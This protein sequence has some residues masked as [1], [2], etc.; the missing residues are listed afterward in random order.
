MEA[1]KITLIDAQADVE[2]KLKGK[3]AHILGRFRGEV[4]LSGRLLLGEGSRV[5][6]K[7][8]ADLA[9]VAG[10][11]KGEIVA[12]VV[13]LAERAR[14]QGSVNAQVLVV[15]EGAQLNGAVSAGPA[16]ASR[17]TGASPP[18]ALSG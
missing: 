4:E 8:A 18:G 3:D 1:N 10:E 15:R 9:E 14:V 2:G 13:L 12:R 11:F 17:G 7:I 16:S 5:D 6:A